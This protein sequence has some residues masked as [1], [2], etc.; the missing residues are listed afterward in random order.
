MKQV[1]KSYF[2]GKLFSLAIIL[3]NSLLPFGNPKL[4]SL[5]SGCSIELEITIGGRVV[6]IVGIVGIVWRVGRVVWIVGR[7]VWIVGRVFSTIGGWIRSLSSANE[8]LTTLS[9]FLLYK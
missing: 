2:T 9:F 8:D 5:Y 1:L 7:V 4:D 3:C 6:G